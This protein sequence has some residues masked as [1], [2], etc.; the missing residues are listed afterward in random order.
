MWTT[1]GTVAAVVVAL[2]IAVVGAWMSRRQAREERERSDR[3]LAE[4]RALEKAAVDEERAHGKAQLEEERRL[5]LEREQFAEAYAVQV[6]LGEAD[7][8]PALTRLAVMVVNRGSF[9]ITRVDAQFCTGISMVSYQS[10]LR[11]PGFMKVP[12]GMRGAYSPVRQPSMNG[13]LTPFDE[14]IVF[15]TDTIHE[16]D[17]SAPYPVVRWTDQWG[18]RWEHKRGVVR[19]VSDTEQWEP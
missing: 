19:R 18:T 3:Q 6:E 15:E 5:A 7:V 12:E 1:I 14:G 17:L 16:K 11:L 10:Y 2:G 9:T 8:P 4:Q 13:V